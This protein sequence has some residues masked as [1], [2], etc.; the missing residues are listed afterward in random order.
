M[1]FYIL[2]GLGV[3]VYVYLKR[4]N[5]KVKLEKVKEAKKVCSYMNMG[6]VLFRIA[7]IQSRLKENGFLEVPPDLVPRAF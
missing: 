5:E 7:Q 4:D 2:V 1:E 6:E 3:L